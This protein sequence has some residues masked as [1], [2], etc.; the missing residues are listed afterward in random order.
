MKFADG[1]AKNVST[2]TFVP[3]ADCSTAKCRQQ[4]DHA[5]VR[6]QRADEPEP[7]NGTAT[8]DSCDI[9]L[10]ALVRDTTV[11]EKG[12]TNLNGLIST[13]AGRA[14]VTIGEEVLG[15]K[16]IAPSP[17]TAGVSDHNAEKILSYHR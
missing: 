12:D 10:G 16:V 13:P 5:C 1:I 7:S 2:V 15:F 11:Q 3:R 8:P 4:L 14:T 17:D 9:N 6:L